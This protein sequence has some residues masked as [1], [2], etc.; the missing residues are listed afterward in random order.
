M[1]AA[2]ACLRPRGRKAASLTLV[3]PGIVPRVDVSFGTK[4]KIAASLLVQPRRMF[5]IPLSD[6][7]LFTDNE[8]MRDYLRHDM[9]RLH[10][11]TARFLSASRCLD[12]RLR[13]CRRGCLTAPTALILARHD[14][15]I[16]N[17]ATRA[18]VGRLTACAAVVRQFDGAHSLEFEP[19]PVPFYKAL[20]EM[21]DPA[22]AS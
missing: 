14:R 19:D 20:S 12:R 5:D 17:D 8:E 6:V 1:L 2:Y 15:I 13:R 9:F 7:E 3:C 10:R 4:L 18:A 16:N 11:A 22:P 21:L